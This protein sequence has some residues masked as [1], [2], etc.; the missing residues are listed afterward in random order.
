MLP[1][2][3][4]IPEMACGEG[5]PQRLVRPRC[6]VTV[7]RHGAGGAQSVP[8]GVDSSTGAQLLSSPP[9][10]GVNLQPQLA[11]V[12]FATNN[13]TLTTVALE[14]PLCMFDSSAALDGTYEIYL[15]VLVDLGEGSASL[16]GTERVFGPCAGRRTG[17]R[18]SDVLALSFS[19][20]VYLTGRHLC[21]SVPALGCA[22]Q[23]HM[24]P[25]PGEMCRLAEKETAPITE[26]IHHARCF[27]HLGAN[28]YDQPARQLSHHRARN[29]GIRGSFQLESESGSLR[30][31]KA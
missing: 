2:L 22:L 9:P 29:Q 12:T 3:R 19:S 6:T 23:P 10:L 18:Q 15:Y 20:P 17:G 28:V 24:R 4:Q 11:S 30:C 25:C 16:G 5:E 27:M 14:K 26:H 7:C 8:M 1:G 21:C 13:P 31:L